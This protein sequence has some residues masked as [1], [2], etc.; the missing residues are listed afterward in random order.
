MIVF[1][2]DDTLYLERDFAF[3]GFRHLDGVAEQRIGL[4]GFGA[5]CSEAFE[6]GE[7]KRVFDAALTALGVRPEASFIA[8]LIAAYRDHLPEISLC[9]DASRYLSRASGPLGLITDGPERTQRNKIAALG[10]ASSIANIRPTGGWPYGFGKPHPR[11]FKEMEN[12]ALNPKAMVYV[13][14]NPAKDFVTP[15]ARGWLTVQVQRQGAVHNP[16]PPD[17]AHAALVQITTL[18]DLDAVLSRYPEARRLLRR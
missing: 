14:D 15:N 13:A 12:K 18:D 9:S 2:L 8:E 3:S 4:S 1:D 6:H 10:I 5:A 7:R 17:Q 11:S 16:R